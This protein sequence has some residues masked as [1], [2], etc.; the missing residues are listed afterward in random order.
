MPIRGPRTRSAAPHPRAAGRRRLA[1]LEGRSVTGAPF[2]SRPTPS[3]SVS[4]PGPEQSSSGRAP[5]ALAHQLDAL[6]RLERADQDGGGA[7]LGLGDRV[8]Q[9]VDPVGEVDVGAPGRAE[10]GLGA[11]VRAAEGVAGRVRLVVGLGL[12]DPP[13]AVARPRA[14]SRSGR[15]RPRARSGRRSPA[16]RGAALTPP[17]ADQHRRRPSSC[18]AAPPRCRR[19]RASTRASVALEHLVVLVVE[20]LRALSELARA[21]ARRGVALLD[22]VPD[23]AADDA[24]GLAE[25]DAP[26]D[27]QVGE[28]GR[29]PA[30]RRSRRRPGARG[31]SS[32]PSSIPVGASRQTSSVSIAS[33]SG[34]LSSCMSLL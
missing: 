25:R 17:A 30:S 3:A 10:Q 23:Q 14:C 29:R 34:S 5:A 27:Q 2:R 26:P 22:R 7:A 6:G 13:A 19:P 16:G 18:S 24:V 31:R 33:K 1:R 4:L 20:Q 11:G 21:G 28:V 12:D 15:A 32:I 9:A 8:Q